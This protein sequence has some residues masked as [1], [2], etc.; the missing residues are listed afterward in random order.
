PPPSPGTQRKIPGHDRRDDADGIAQG[1]REIPALDGNRLAVDLVRP[2][3]VVLEAF[4][5]RRDLDVPRFEDRLAVVHGLEAR[6]L[7]GALEN[8]MG[9]LREEAPAI[10]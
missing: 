10:P 7:V 4:R 9:D 6:E 8:P 1:V 2:S 3:R 5:R